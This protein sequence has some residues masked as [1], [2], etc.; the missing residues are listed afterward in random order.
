MR[1]LS[2]SLGEPV[3]KAYSIA[4]AT[5]VSKAKIANAS[6]LHQNYTSQGPKTKDLGRVAVPAP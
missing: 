4:L 1:F 2:Q 6:L 5:M 3:D